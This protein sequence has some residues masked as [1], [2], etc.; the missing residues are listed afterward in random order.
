MKSLQIRAA[1]LGDIEVV[2]NLG[3]ESYLEHF[4]HLWT[5]QGIRRFLEADFSEP[6]LRETLAAP[7]RHLWLLAGEPERKPAGFARINWSMPD[8]V[9]GIEGAELQKIYFCK[10]AAGKGY[11][12]ALMQHIVECV[13][14]RACTRI[15]L[16]V[17]KTNVNAQRFYEKAGFRAIGELPFKTDMAEIGMIV[18]AKAV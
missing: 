7:A 13:R 6:A 2:R 3:Y 9:S 14:A 18:M 17:L 12:G 8:P 5:P 1:Q 10:S 15:W 11:G 4:S 16:D